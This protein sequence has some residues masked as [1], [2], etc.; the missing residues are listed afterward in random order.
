VSDEIRT[1]GDRKIMEICTQCTAE[2]DPL[3]VFPEGKCLE[4]HAKAFV[5]PT[6]TELKAMWGI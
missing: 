1:K 2:I 6:E 4:C 3:E 5:M